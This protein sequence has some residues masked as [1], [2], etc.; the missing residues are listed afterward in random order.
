MKN[1]NLNGSHK[2]AQ[3]QAAECNSSNLM[4]PSISSTIVNCGQAISVELVDARWMK[5][6]YPDR[7]ER[8]ELELLPQLPPGALVKLC[9]L[10]ICDDFVAERFWVKLTE[11]HVQEDG[12]LEYLGV[13]AHDTFLFSANDLIGPMKTQCFYD[14]DIDKL[15]D[16]IK[17]NTR[18]G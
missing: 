10:P 11:A 5:Q 13:L 8:H 18:G 3:E 15:I 16:M 2:C 6:A 14:L 12:S 7:F 9:C 1:K 4:T 17:P